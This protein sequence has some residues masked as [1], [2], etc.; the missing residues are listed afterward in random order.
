MNEVIKKEMLKNELYLKE[1]ACLNKDAIHLKEYKEDIR[2]SYFRDIDR[3]I[4]SSAYTRYLDKTQVFSFVN[5]DNV[6]KRIIHVNLVSKLARTI[7]RA[8]SLNED[9]IEAIALGHDLGHV[10]FGHVGER[11]LNDISLKY[12]NTYFNHNVQSVRLLMDLENN[13]KGLNLSLQTLDG[14]LCHNGELCL[15]KYELIYKDVELF[16]KQY[17][18]C[19]I[20]QNQ[21]KQLIPMTL[22][23]CVVRICD[24]IAYIGRDIEDAI[25]LN[26]INKDE[27]P[28][29]I[30]DILG[31][32]NKTIVNTLLLDIINNSINK[33][34]IEMSKEVFTAMKD[35]KNFNYKY[36]Y[37]KAYTSEELNNYEYM[38][39][40]LFKYYLDNIDN[41][42]N[43]INKIFLN[44]MTDDYIKNTNNNRKVID[45]L[46]GMT[47]EFFMKQYNKYKIDK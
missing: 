15:E 21:I 26:I 2:P 34:Y 19:Y 41:E 29:E 23:G 24:I 16:L 1:Y 5:N 3:I 45:Y 40:Y 47:D 42:D 7:G 10:P 17:N 44:D 32:D 9:L 33:P 30:V 12:D 43:D 37:D 6:T 13:G 11:I 31:D 27:I 14:I 36:I 46:S 25:M 20:D 39:N 22:E 38:F 18:N 35:L 4:H 8:L 28:K